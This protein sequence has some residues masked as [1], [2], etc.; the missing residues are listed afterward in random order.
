MKSF[1]GAAVFIAIGFWAA[2][3][4]GSDTCDPEGEYPYFQRRINWLTYNDDIYGLEL[5][6][7]FYTQSVE[8]EDGSASFQLEVKKEGMVVSL[9]NLTSVRIGVWPSCNEGSVPNGAAKFQVNLSEA[10]IDQDNLVFQIPVTEMPIPNCLSQD[11]IC[12]VAA[13]KGFVGD[14]QTPLRISMQMTDG[15]QCPSSTPKG[16]NGVTQCPISLD[17]SKASPTPSPSPTPFQVCEK[18]IEAAGLEPTFTCEGESNCSTT[19]DLVVRGTSTDVG[20]LTY[21]TSS[22][23]GE[24]CFHLVMS[25]NS[26]GQEYTVTAMYLGLWG[27]NQDLGEIWGNNEEFQI[28]DADPDSPL[29]WDICPS[30]LIYMPNCI[31]INDMLYLGTIEVSNKDGGWF[32]NPSES[33]CPYL[34]G[35]PFQGCPVNVEWN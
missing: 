20:T 30:M 31:S 1:C 13:F 14:T 12:M 3:A 18:D 26:A 5:V 28:A 27:A 8:N 25:L 32:F 19:V 33:D 29:E 2:T 9:T 23:N 15:S 6:G 7:K 4:A 16:P 35:I 22:V 21:S 34:N 24:R 10:D 11:S 17:W